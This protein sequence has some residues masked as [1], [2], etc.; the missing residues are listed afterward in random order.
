MKALYYNQ[1][2]APDVLEFGEL[3]IP[4]DFK[5]NSGFLIFRIY[6]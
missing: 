1:H 5:I 3:P 6:P 4:E 2:G